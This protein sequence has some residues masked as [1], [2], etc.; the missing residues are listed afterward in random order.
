M[1]ELVL[2]DS[3]MDFPSWIVPWVLCWIGVSNV[4]RFPCPIWI[5]V[6]L[7]GML[8]GVVFGICAMKKRVFNI[9]FTGYRIAL[10]KTDK[11]ASAIDA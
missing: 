7:I 10:I 8:I 11:S 2:E 1:V 4:R 9:R 5:R 3:H 6:K